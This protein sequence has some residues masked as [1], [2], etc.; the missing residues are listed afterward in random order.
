MVMA[1]KVLDKA[2]CIL[3]R[4]NILGEKYA[5]NNFA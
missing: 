1:T 5:S 3:H 4:A 2:V